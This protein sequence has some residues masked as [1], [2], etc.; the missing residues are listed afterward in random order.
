MKETYE[1]E[2]TTVLLEGIREK[3]IRVVGKL[4]GLSIHSVSLYTQSEDNDIDCEFLCEIWTE[5]IDDD[6]TSLK[7]YGYE[8]VILQPH[9]KELFEYIKSNLN[10]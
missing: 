7:E 3:K 2:L 5:N 10:K 4:I 8:P 9:R 1:K 6:L